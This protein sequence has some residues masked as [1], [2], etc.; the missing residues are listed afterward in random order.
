MSSIKVMSIVGTRPEAIKMAPLIRI[1][2]ET[3]EIKSVLCLTAQH[4]EMLDQVLSLFKLDPDY[5]LDIMKEA[6]SLTHITVRALEGLDKVLQKEKPDLVLVQG[7]TTTTMAGSLAAFYQKIAV[8]HIEAGLRTGERYAPFPEEINRRLNSVIA[9]LHFAPTDLAR[10]N[11]LR[12]GFDPNTIFV[13]GNTVIDALQ[14]T[15]QPKFSFS[16][17]LLQK[18][19]FSRY[20]IL[21]VEAH[22]RENLGEPMESIALALRDLLETFPDTFLVFPVHKNPQVRKVVFRLL[23]DHPR[24]LLLEPLD[25]FSFHNLMARAHLILTDSGGIQEE[26]PS[27]GRPVLVLRRVTERP[28]ALEAG[29]ALLAGTKREEIVALAG[30]LLGDETAYQAMAHAT[31]PYGDGQASR[32]ICQAILYHFGRRPSPPEP[33]EPGK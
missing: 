8:G 14:T 22:R 16:D 4:R 31:N 1:L 29:T 32:R 20:R 21:L 19:D 5:D 6:Q 3:G 15:I 17:P 25:P 24:V 12:E 10:E 27:L 23:Q 11:L 28:E 7:D 18:V 26:A 33:F 2:Q 30:G 9:Q 13:T